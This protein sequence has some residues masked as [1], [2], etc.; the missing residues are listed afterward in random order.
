MSLCVTLGI[1]L[2]CMHCYVVVSSSQ[3]FFNWNFDCTEDQHPIRE[4]QL[5]LPVTLPATQL[6]LPTYTAA[7]Y[8]RR[9]GWGELGLSL[10]GSGAASRLLSCGT[11]MTQLPGRV[12]KEGTGVAAYT[13]EPVQCYMR[14]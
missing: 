10:K 9:V 2:N 3:V 1:S 14:T 12:L 4:S 8:V 13:P 11:R 6:L 7:I 5:L